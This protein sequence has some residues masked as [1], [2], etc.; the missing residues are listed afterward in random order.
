[1]TLPPSIQVVSLPPNFVVQIEK[2]SYAVLASV[3][4][5][6]W[7]AAFPAGFDHFTNHNN[8]IFLFEPVAV[9]QDIGQGILRKVL[10]WAVRMSA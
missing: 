1:M 6:H 2:E 10:R 4:C 5:S 9:M 8:L 3:Q 7:L